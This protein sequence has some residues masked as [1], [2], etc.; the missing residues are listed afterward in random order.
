MKL[1]FKYLLQMPL[2]FFLLIGV[3]SIA[4]GNLWITVLVTI[5]V[6]FLYTTGDY[7]DTDE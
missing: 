7:L 4:D 3:D 6:L 2:L 5:G 1:V